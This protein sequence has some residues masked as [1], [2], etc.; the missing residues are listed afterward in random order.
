LFVFFSGD[1]HTVLFKDLSKEVI[2]EMGKRINADHHTTRRILQSF[3]IPDHFLTNFGDIFHLFPDTPV[4]LL[5]DACEALQL[6]DLVELLEKPIPHLTKSLR[7][8]LT[9]DEVRKLGK[10]DGRPMSHHSRAAV[11]IFANSEDDSNVKSFESFFKSLN[12]K[13]EVTIVQYNDLLKLARRREEIQTEFRL[14]TAKAELQRSYRSIEK[15]VRRGKQWQ[16]VEQ[17]NEMMKLTSQLQMQRQT[18]EQLEK[19][20]EENKAKEKK[21]EENIK[22]AAS[23]VIDR[24]IQRQGWCKWRKVLSLSTVPPN[25]DVFL[26]RL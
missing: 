13:S 19:E 5:R 9:L 21:E 16:Q 10:I 12:N 14:S 2:S 26:Q 1:T 3:E 8:V 6:Y 22:T 23:K 15:R 7:P 24:W 18:V 4:K 11:L 17:Q 20:L 25:R